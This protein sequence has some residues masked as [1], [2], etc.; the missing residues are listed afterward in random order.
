MKVNKRI[1]RDGQAAT[2][3]FDNRRL[4]VDYRTLIPILKKGMLVLDVGFGTGSISRD[5][6]NIIGV[7]LNH[8]L[9]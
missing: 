8:W 7:S 2:K 5:I 9:I 6:A 4:K 1:D 3:I